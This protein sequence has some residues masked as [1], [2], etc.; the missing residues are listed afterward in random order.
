MILLNIYHKV[1]IVFLF[2]FLLNPILY[3]LLML[4]Y[5]I[6]NNYNLHL[7]ILQVLFSLFRFSL[8]VIILMLSACLMSIYSWYLY[9]GTSSISDHLPTYFI[10][11]PFRI[12]II[13]R[14]YSSIF[15]YFIFIIESSFIFIYL[16]IIPF[17]HLRHFFYKS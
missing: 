6:Y 4:N 1:L 14:I 12:W 2:H 3:L 17:S 9:F 10:P 13:C 15:W 16:F 7:L 5:R 11:I 8:N